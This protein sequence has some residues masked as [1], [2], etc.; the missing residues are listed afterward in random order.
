MPEYRSWQVPTPHPHTLALSA[1]P[2]QCLNTEKDKVLSGDWGTASEGKKS[3]YRRPG[4]GGV[5]WLE[6]QKSAMVTVVQ[7]LGTR[8][9][10]ASPSPI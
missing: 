2:A 8:I 10:S 9:T 1:G 6:F 5:P 3:R 4:A 7:A